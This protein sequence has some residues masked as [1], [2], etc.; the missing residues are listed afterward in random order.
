MKGKLKIFNCDKDFSIGLDVDQANKSCFESIE[1]TMKKEA[2]LKERVNLIKGKK[3][4]KFIQNSTQ[5]TKEK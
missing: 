3:I 4:E 5:M 2:C 1:E